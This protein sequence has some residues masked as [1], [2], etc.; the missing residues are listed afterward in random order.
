MSVSESIDISTLF[1]I[2][3]AIL[4]TLAFLGFISSSWCW[5]APYC[6]LAF[7]FSPIPSFLSPCH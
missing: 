7:P 1:F 2:V 4:G 5:P 6:S 3:V